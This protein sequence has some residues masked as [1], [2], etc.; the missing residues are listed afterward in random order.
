VACSGCAEPGG[1]SAAIAASL[2]AGLIDLFPAEL[3]DFWGNDYYLTAPTDDRISNN[4]ASTSPN[5]KFGGDYAGL[6]PCVPAL[7]VGGFNP[8]DPSHPKGYRPD[9]NYPGKNVDYHYYDIGVGTTPL[10][11]DQRYNYD[12]PGYPYDAA[13]A[14]Y[15]PSWNPGPDGIVGTADDIGPDGIPATADDPRI[16]RIPGIQELYPGNPTLDVWV[17]ECD[18]RRGCPG[19]PGLPVPE[20]FQEWWGYSYWNQIDGTEKNAGCIPFSNVRVTG[21]RAELPLLPAPDLGNGFTPVDPDVAQGLSFPPPPGPVYERRVETADGAGRPLAS[22]FG[23]GCTGE[24]G[25]DG[26]A[27]WP[28][29]NRDPKSYRSM[30]LEGIGRDPA[31]LKPGGAAGRLSQN[32]FT[33]ARREEGDTLFEGFVG[34]GDVL[35]AEVDDF[36]NPLS[37]GPATPGASVVPIPCDPALEDHCEPLRYQVEPGVDESG[38]YGDL[39]D[40]WSPQDALE[41]QPADQ[42][43]FACVCDETIPF[44]PGVDTGA[45]ALDLFNSAQVL[46][47]TLAPF[48]FAEILTCFLAGETGGDCE[49]FYGTIASNLQRH[50]LFRPT[51]IVPLNRDANDGVITATSPVINGDYGS[52]PAGDFLCSAIRQFLPGPDD[53]LTLDSSLSNQQ[54][55]HLG[56][57]PYWG[58]RCDSSTKVPPGLYGL[59]VCG[60]LG[61]GCTQGGGIDLLGAEASAL[62]QSFVRE[63]LADP[64]YTSNPEHPEYAQWAE[65]GANFV[66]TPYEGAGIWLTTSGLPQPGTVGAAGGPVCTRYSEELNEVVVLP[67]CRGIRKVLNRETAPSDGVVRFEFDDGYDPRVDGCVLGATIDGIPVEAVYA[68]G[69]PVDLSGC[70]EDSD[71]KIGLFFE[72]RGQALLQLSDSVPTGATAAPGFKTVKPGARTLWH[73]FAGCF[74]S[75]GDPSGGPAAAL[76]GQTCLVTLTNAEIDALQSQGLVPNDAD[77]GLQQLPGEDGRDYEADFFSSDIN[78]QSQIFRSEMAALSWNFTQFLIATSCSY[79]ADDIEGDPECFNPVTPYLV[80]KCSWVTPQLCRSAKFF[81]GLTLPLPTAERTVPDACVSLLAPGIDIKPGS[82]SNP[83]NPLGRGVIPVA[84]LGSENFDVAEVD[85]AT[86][87]FGPGGAAPT[88]KK[89]G[90]QMDVNRDGFPDLLSHYRTQESGIS[91]G[92]TEACVTGELRG[93]RPFEG[94][95]AIS[96]RPRCGNGFETALALSPLVWI[97]GRMR[98]RRR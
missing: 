53:L 8:L 85:V 32:G 68:N 41:S 92:D 28:S 83:I 64:R 49:V 50:P 30:T 31:C 52:C 63:D 36:G 51:G 89:G 33:V 14:T 74:G 93:G 5:Q 47:P 17:F 16:Q 42:G 67:G 59:D 57:G 88:D 76:A 69:S 81:L 37:S 62:F 80:G 44:L 23:S 73:P 48:P 91:L 61:I 26:D 12:D 66:G 35:F 94:C 96:T 18:P 21:G 25:E 20:E 55:A 98:R 2:D 24:W 4:V 38:V 87:A 82:D 10:P 40:G 9:W 27:V 34:V 19:E 90:H 13:T 78:R 72:N 77:H 39:A 56:C 60:L 1:F 22:G 97:G 84:L 75:A 29:A 54:R 95:D 86:L 71:S 58:T 7:R 46:D 3:E 45:C 6:V 43:T 15:L 65:G 11:A 79:G 70:F